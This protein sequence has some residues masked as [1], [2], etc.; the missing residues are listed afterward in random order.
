MVT[1]IASRLKFSLGYFATTTATADQLFL[2]MWKAIGFVS[3]KASPN[4]RFYSLHDSGDKITYRTKNV[5]ATDEQR[6]V[7]FISDPPHLIK[8][9]RNNLANSGSGSNTRRLCVYLYTQN[10]LHIV[11]H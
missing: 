7:Y 5:F 4:Q 8:T 10:N 1:G 9:A 3:D 6:Y 11:C 2:L